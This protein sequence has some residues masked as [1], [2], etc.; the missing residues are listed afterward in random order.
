[1]PED[2]PQHCTKSSHAVP[3]VIVRGA[4]L[5]SR[6]ELG[7]PFTAA[8]PHASEQKSKG[9]N[10]SV[11]VLRSLEQPAGAIFTGFP[12]KL[13]EGESTHMSSYSQG[14]VMY[15]DRPT[16]DGRQ[17]YLLNNSFRG[18]SPVPSENGNTSVRGGVGLVFRKDDGPTPSSFLIVSEVS[19]TECSDDPVFC[20]S[21]I[22]SLALISLELN[23]CP[24]V[25]HGG[26]AFKSGMI[27]AGDRLRKIDGVELGAC[28]FLSSVTIRSCR[29][30]ETNWCSSTELFC[31]GHRI[32]AR[33]GIAAV[34][35]TS[36]I[37][38]DAHARTTLEGDPI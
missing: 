32:C 34:A 23:P 6:I 30:V 24:Q 29:R 5:A 26:P 14:S 28:T 38:S 22:L 10:L 11:I 35:W 37:A 15:S 9:T 21:R 16:V 3:V 7:T 27:K 18:S 4:P 2:A 1:M 19:S 33:R 13:S 17:S 36:R 20:T 12:R 8:S 31:G 25:L